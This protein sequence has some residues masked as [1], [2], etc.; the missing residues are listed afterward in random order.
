MESTKESQSHSE[1]E[2]VGEEDEDDEEG[3]VGEEMVG[4]GSERVDGSE[5][6]TSEGGEV[7]DSVASE[8]EMGRE[9]EESGDG[10]AQS[11]RAQEQTTAREKAESPP[12]EPP[13][14]GSSSPTTSQLENRLSV[15]ASKEKEIRK[16]A[17]IDAFKG[18]AREKQKYHSRRGAA[19]IGRAKG[20]KAKQDNR[21]KVDKS[22]L[23]D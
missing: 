6:E 3:E 10:S 1:G 11:Q 15:N 20:S 17:A 9:D 18:R 4:S 21:V 7:E 13:R 16:K 8:E 5:R 22:G 14:S 12:R 2:D 19:R 23:W